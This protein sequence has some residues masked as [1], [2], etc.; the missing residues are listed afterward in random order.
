VRPGEADKGTSGHIHGWGAEGSAVVLIIDG[1]S[2]GSQAQGNASQRRRGMGEFA[3]RLRQ[4]QPE[5]IMA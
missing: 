4:A 5:P 2:G 1:I 3:A